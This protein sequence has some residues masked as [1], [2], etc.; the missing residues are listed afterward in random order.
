VT[1]P[2]GEELGEELV[3][4]LH[5]HF[6]PPDL[7]DLT[8]ETNDH[9]W[10][11]LVADDNA[12][13]GRVLRGAELFRVVRRPCWDAATRVAEMDHL[14]VDLQVISPIPVSLTYWAE[15]EASLRYARHLNDWAARVAWQSGGRLRAMG[16]VP[17]QD[18]DLA[19]AELTRA[20]TELD[21]AGIEL[22]TV[23]GHAELDAPGLRPFFAAA[24]RL[25]VPLFVHPMDPHVVGR[26]RSVEKAFGIGMLTD[27]A[28]AASALV[29]GGVLSEFPRLRI[30]LSHGGGALPWMLPRLKL[31][32]SLHDPGLD[33]VW[34][35]LVA[36]F[37][38]DSLVFDP[39]HLDLLTR[40][41][42]AD[43]IVAGSD[44]PFLPD[45]PAPHDLLNS[46]AR[47]GIVS[48]DQAR[49][50]KGDN[51]LAFLGPRATSP[52]ARQATGYRVDR[53][54]GK[55]Q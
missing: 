15:P 14:G 44:Y 22:G 41:F 45:G 28:L 24:E 4:D 21:L 31:G 26:A 37:Y 42:G 49:S 33:E 54:R 5:A 19:I 55:V 46:A 8:A 3:I 35:Q 9:R 16:S 6:M 43:H 2:E 47:L 48:D 32:R 13:T 20:V 7:P 36:R 11:R 30:C 51:A 52:P 39:R 23:V 17:L 10:P 29:F 12:K 53:S 34:D 18:T 40:R 27:T 1:E 38:V 25:N 50:M